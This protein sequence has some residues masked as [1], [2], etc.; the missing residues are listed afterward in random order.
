MRRLRNLSVLAVVVGG[1]LCSPVASAAG[2]VIADGA[3]S[4][5]TVVVA[6]D[7]SP[8]ERHGAKELQMFL[9]EISGATLPIATDTDRVQG[10]MILLGQSK[11]LDALAKI[12][13]EALGDE[14]FVMRTAPPHLILAG[15]RQ[16]GSRY[17]V[18]TFL[19]EQ[20]GCRWFTPT[21]CRIPKQ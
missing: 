10:P 21:A 12:D 11:K 20:L 3:K 1:F 7:A 8:S 16:R 15:G 2:L 5:Y 18:Y 9:K 19:E 4:A 14:G 6:S 13:F 17:A